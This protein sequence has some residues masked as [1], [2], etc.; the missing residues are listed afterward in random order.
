MNNTFLQGTPLI[1]AWHFNKPDGAVF[2]LDGYELKLQYSAGHRYSDATGI[3][4]VGNTVSWTFP[5]ERQKVSGE[6]NLKLYIFQNGKLFCKFIYDRAFTLYRGG[7]SSSPT[8]EASGEEQVVDL[9]TTAEFY[10]FQPIIPA[11]GNDGYWYVNGEHV[12]DSQGRWISAS[13]TVRFD[14]DTQH[15]IID[16]GRTD[17]N[18]DSIEQVITDVATALARWD[19]SYQTA[20]SDRN[21]SYAEAEAERNRLSSAAVSRANKAANDANAAAESAN[22]AAGA[23]NEAAESANGAAAAANEAAESANEAKNAADEASLAANEAAGG[24]NTAAERANTAAAAAEH[25]VDVKRGYGI[26]SVTQPVASQEPGGRNVVRVTTEDGRTFDFDIYNGRDSHGL[27][28]TSQDLIDALPAPVVGDYAFVGASFPAAL[29]VCLEDGI[30][31]NSG[32]TYGGP[33]GLE[34]V[35]N[36]TSGGSTKALSAEQGKVLEGKVSQLG[37]DISQLEAKVIDLEDNFN[38]EQ[39]PHD[40]VVSVSNP[41]DGYVKKDGTTGGS[42]SY[43]NTGEVSVSPGDTIAC[44]DADGYYV[45]SR[46]VCAKS[47][48]EVVSSAGE[49]YATNYLVPNGIDAVILST[50]ASNTPLYYRHVSQQEKMTIKSSSIEDGSV[51]ETKL[52]SSAVTTAKIANSAVTTEKVADKAVTKGKLSDEL[53]AEI[54]SES[55]SDYFNTIPGENLFNPEK[56]V[57]GYWNG[58]EAS[59]PD[60]NYRYEK[61]D[62][63]NVPAGSNLWCIGSD[64]FSK[65][66]RFCQFYN[67]DTFVS[68]VA[69]LG[70]TEIPSVANSVYVSIAVSTMPDGKPANVGIF[71]SEADTPSWSPYYEIP[72]AKWTTKPENGQALA[73]LADIQGNTDV[74]AGKKWVACGDSFTHGD[75]TDSPTEDY[76]IE[77]GQYAGQYKVYPFLIGNRVGMTIINEAVNGSTLTHIDGRDSAFSDTRYQQIPAD[78]DYITIKIGINDDSS[79]RNVPIGTIGDATNETFYGAWNVVLDYIIQHHPQAK[80]GIIVTNGSN[81]AIVNAT[82]AIAEKWGIPYLNEA[83]D[84]Q[85]SFMFRSNRADVL[86]SVKTFRDNYWHVSNVSG[87]L[88]YHPNAKAHEYE[89]SVIEA[90]LRT[91]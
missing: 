6:H 57:V 8:S 9:F 60:P 67:G 23:A 42:G 31:S 19:D 16:E 37:Q 84:K 4:V 82:I 87:S 89:A 90:W 14:E 7:S 21:E 88:N 59:T 10:L 41:V 74:L 69:N 43:I 12:L 5:A 51:S 33:T 15:I 61:I 28:A 77:T 66:M 91:L 47:N 48:G 63:S 32:S 17:E 78:A 20:E 68:G 76:T 1:I 44:C 73:R 83:T 11:V 25:Q 71:L 58:G 86:S 85:C 26:E 49:E 62:L 54:E 65:S 53:V 55:F 75:F 81:L 27:Y 39:I 30:W 56:V 80:I 34:I 36:L 64:G 38:S 18:G 35:D 29:Y 46:F 72:V 22:G 50:S 79:H 24:A 2:N 13:H 70:M 45:S 40:D 3:N 52:A